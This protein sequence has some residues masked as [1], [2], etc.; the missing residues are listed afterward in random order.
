MEL[1]RC[2]DRAFIINLPERTD[3]RRDMEQQLQRFGL[4][5]ADG[6]EP[7]LCTRADG[8]EPGDGEGRNGRQGEDLQRC[9]ASARD[10]RRRR[11]LR[12]VARPGESKRKTNRESIDISFARAHDLAR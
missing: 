2:F 8:G 9:R 4:S 6:I 12:I 7:E 10:L 3:R 1:F 5:A 11:L